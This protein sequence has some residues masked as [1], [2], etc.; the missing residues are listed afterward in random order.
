MCSP[1]RLKYIA[2]S[3]CFQTLRKGIILKKMQKIVNTTSDNDSDPKQ[4]EGKQKN[5]DN[6][7]HTLASKSGF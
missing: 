5:I 3:V 7:S 4:G 1:T 6:T 2:L